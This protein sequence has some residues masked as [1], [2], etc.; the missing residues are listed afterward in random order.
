MIP[1]IRM[2]QTLSSHCRQLYLLDMIDCRGRYKLW[3]CCLSKSSSYAITTGTTLRLPY[4]SRD[5]NEFGWRYAFPT[6]LK[7]EAERL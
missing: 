6:E 5:L 2:T 7:L 4:A 1:A 3:L